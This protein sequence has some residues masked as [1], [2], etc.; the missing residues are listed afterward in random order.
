MI[1]LLLNSKLSKN[2][3]I[4]YAVEKF[5]D[6]P[7]RVSFDNVALLLRHLHESICFKIL[8]SSNLFLKK[9]DEGRRYQVVARRPMTNCPNKKNL[10]KHFL[11]EH[12]ISAL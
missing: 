10:L 2:V 1:H 6:T 11:H 5:A 3:V 12:G 9:N 8:G 7:E 4:L